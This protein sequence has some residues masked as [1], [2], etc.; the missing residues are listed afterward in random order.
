VQVVKTAFGGLL[1]LDNIALAAEGMLRNFGTA[2]DFQARQMA[3]RCA[4]RRDTVGE[5][6]WLDIGKQIVAIRSRPRER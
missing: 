4:S 2:A 5:L 3:T 6:L 1:P